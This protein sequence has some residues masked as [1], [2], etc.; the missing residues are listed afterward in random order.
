MPLE[1]VIPRVVQEAPAG[2]AVS[3]IVLKSVK[4]DRWNNVVSLLVWMYT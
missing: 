2:L 3:R 1:V 4:I